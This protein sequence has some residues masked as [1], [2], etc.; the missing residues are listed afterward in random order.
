MAE[1]PKN[2]RDKKLPPSKF[3]D[4][5]KG[6]NQPVFIEANRNFLSDVNI[7]VSASVVSVSPRDIVSDSFITLEDTAIIPNSG[8]SSSFLP[9]ENLVFCLVNLCL[10]PSFLRRGDVLE[11]ASKKYIVAR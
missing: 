7:P 2:P 11:A 5:Q 10:G 9:N 1:K 8:L 6:N 3:V 4:A